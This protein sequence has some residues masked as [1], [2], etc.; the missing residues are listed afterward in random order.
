[1]D[2]REKVGKRVKELRNK[3]GVS[4][5]E[6]A[7]MVELDRTYITS[8][9]CGR[10]NISIVNIEKLTVALKFTLSDFFDFDVDYK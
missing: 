3:L 8:V 1:M 6:L 5:E 10:R 2:I 4:Q 7:D 9:E